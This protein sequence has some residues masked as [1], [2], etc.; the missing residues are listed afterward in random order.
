MNKLFLA[1]VIKLK[2]PLNLRKIRF[3]KMIS[4]LLGTEGPSKKLFNSNELFT[5]GI[6]VTGGF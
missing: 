1:V 2:N 6:M 5:F 4:C 3:W